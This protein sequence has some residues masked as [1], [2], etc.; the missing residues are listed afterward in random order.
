MSY[1]DLPSTTIFVYGI[2]SN[3]VTT[4]AVNLALSL[5]Q[6]YGSTLILDGDLHYGIVGD[7]LGIHEGMT[8]LA[9]ALGESQPTKHKSGLQAITASNRSHLA[10]T[11]SD[12][13][14]KSIVNYARQHAAIVVIDGGRDLND[15]TLPFLMSSDVI[16]QVVGTQ[17]EDIMR[18]R[19]SSR[20]FTDL[21]II[22][23]LVLVANRVNV[24][25]DNDFL[26][27]LDNFYGHPVFTAIQNEPKIRQKLVETGGQW[28][29]QSSIFRQEIEA[30]GSYI[31][32][33]TNLPEWQYPQTLQTSSTQSDKVRIL[34][35]DDIAQTIDSIK[36]LLAFEQ[37]FEVVGAASN[38][39]IGV[40]MALDLLPDIVIMDINMPDMDGLE[41]T[42]RILQQTKTVGV[43]IMSVQNDA[44]YLGLAMRAGARDFLSK[45]VNMDELY[46]TIRNVYKQYEPMRRAHQATRGLVNIGIIR[47]QRIKQAGKMTPAKP[48]DV[49]AS[50]QAPES[51]VHQA[52]LD[53]N[54]VSEQMR[55]VEQNPLSLHLL[56]ELQRWGSGTAHD[57]RS[58]ISN[59][60]E[61]LGQTL[62]RNQSDAL[63]QL[64]QHLSV[65]LIESNSFLNIAG[66]THHHISKINLIQCLL[67]AS[68]KLE[69]IHD[70]E[71]SLSLQVE[72][73]EFSGDSR[74][75]DVLSVNLVHVLFQI[76]TENPIDVRRHEKGLLFSVRTKQ[77]FSNVEQWQNLGSQTP[78]EDASLRLYLCGRILRSANS[79]LSIKATNNGLEISIHHQEIKVE[80]TFAELDSLREK[81]ENMR[82][83]VSR[84]RDERLNDDD[85]AQVIDETHKIIRSF[86]KKM[87]SH[88]SD[89]QDK[90]RAIEF[91]NESQSIQQSALRNLRYCELLIRSLHATMLGAKPRTHKITIQQIL[92]D[93]ASLMATKAT[94][95][96]IQI[97][98]TI[99]PNDLV[100]ET[101]DLLLSQI[102]MNLLRN[103]IDA[104]DN[105]KP[106]STIMLLASQV[107]N[108]TIIEIVDNGMGIPPEN[109]EKIGKERFTTK[110]G[111]GIGLM[112]VFDLANKIGCE[113]SFIS[114]LNRGTLFRLTFSEAET[115]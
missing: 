89:L 110:R 88:L 29:E 51:A 38:G 100:I 83:E 47:H 63:N 34:I 68:Q 109:L 37:D 61:A 59:V 95:S 55:V 77:T 1:P 20:L 64:R 23:R 53:Y 57:I 14:A 9:A 54:D 69:L 4:V 108:T 111:Y 105:E 78:F 81:T 96:D 112:S 6:Q 65:V 26:T 93:I 67:D 36:K 115:A 86:S 90:V 10:G 101:D 75:L 16:I 31:A 60:Q 79:N 94:A 66:T 21:G 104:K 12:E 99:E 84:V 18:L 52:L 107:E 15:V 44:K 92:N 8:L 48:N 82:A 102:I 80:W 49:I 46:T 11:L 27:Q 3:G 56:A 43:L 62:L 91:E 42:T 24:E 97:V 5:Q 33:R 17:Y 76:S 41:A 85:R 72:E 35:V 71:T 19:T 50:T 28:M 7:A 58:P 74:L 113:I 30:V 98:V 106:L 103:S 2:G 40:E 114:E 39:R 87:F 25:V 13:A 22:E 70:V 32:S 73:H 45:P